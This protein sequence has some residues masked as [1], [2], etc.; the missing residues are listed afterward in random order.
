VYTFLALRFLESAGSLNKTD[1]TP[2]SSGRNANLGKQRLFLNCICKAESGRKSKLA[3]LLLSR[4]LLV[5]RQ[6]W[7]PFLRTVILISIPLVDN[8]NLYCVDFWLVFWNKDNW[9]IILSQCLCSK[10]LLGFFG[11][12]GPLKNKGLMIEVM[13][14][15]IYK[16]LQIAVWLGYCDL[17]NKVNKVPAFLELWS[18]L[19]GR[20]HWISN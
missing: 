6:A 17:F 15:N 14:S 16:H 19:L 5:F 12:G 18:I 11:G 3:L 7:F 9:E 2:W 8:W 4:V 20:L 1:K 13:F 10:H